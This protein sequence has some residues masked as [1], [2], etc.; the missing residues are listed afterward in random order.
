MIAKGRQARDTGSPGERH[1]AAKLDERKV[2]L[3]RTLNR[4]GRPGVRIA[5]LLDV[6]KATVYAVISGQNWSHVVDPLRGMDQ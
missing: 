3:I 4:M 2:I 1:P 6:H 5:R